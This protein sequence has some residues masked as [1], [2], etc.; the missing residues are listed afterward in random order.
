MYCIISRSTFPANH[1][2][3][4]IWHW[5]EKQ[6][7]LAPIIMLTPHYSVKANC[8]PDT[9]AGERKREGVL[10]PPAHVERMFLHCSSPHHPPRVS[11]DSLQAAKLI[12]SMWITLPLWL[13]NVTSLKIIFVQPTKH[14][15]FSVKE[16]CCSKACKQ[17]SHQVRLQHVERA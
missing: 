6:H 9:H 17:Q 7:D 2:L 3:V 1:L 14:D 13:P 12:D 10:S 15:L 5:E 8:A 16:T 4:R 11:Q